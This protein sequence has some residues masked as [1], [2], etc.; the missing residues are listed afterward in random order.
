MA[1]FEQG[2]AHSLGD[3]AMC[4]A[5]QD[6]RV[7]GTADIID[8]GIADDL[9]GTRIGI[10]LDL[11]D[12]RA[13]GKARDREGLVGNAGKRPLRFPR[14]VGGASPQAADVLLVQEASSLS[15]ISRGS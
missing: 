6:Q 10:D 4:L 13:V 14:Q 1:V 12:L 15:L 11:A 5:V 3:A 8:R 9:D 7:D 2:L